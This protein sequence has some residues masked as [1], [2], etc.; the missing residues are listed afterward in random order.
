MPKE[1]RIPFEEINNSQTITENMDKRF[2]ANDVDLHKN[3]VT[4]LQDDF[5]KQE[6]ILKIKNMKFF[7]I[8][9]VPLKR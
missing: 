5:K 9:D 6:R 1:V 3:E 4:D 8:G 2:K 7:V